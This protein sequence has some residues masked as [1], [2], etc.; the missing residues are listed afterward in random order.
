MNNYLV[1]RHYVMIGRYYVEASSMTEA[2]VK[3][4]RNI[5]A[6]GLELLEDTAEPIGEDLFRIKPEGQEEWTDAETAARE[7][8]ILVE[9]DITAQELANRL[10]DKALDL[11]AIEGD[12]RGPLERAAESF[13][14]SPLLNDSIIREA[15]DIAWDI[16][17]AHRV[18]EGL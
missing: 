12:P 4:D 6:D 14:Y 16:T 15:Q 7:A 17:Q 11:G 3:A 5:Y 1:E 2:L 18:G 8:G 9:S 10:A 13:I